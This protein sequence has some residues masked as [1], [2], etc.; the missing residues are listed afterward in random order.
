MDRNEI[1][2][3]A[4]HSAWYAYTVLALNEEGEPW[5][6][7]PEWQKNSIRDAVRFWDEELAKA[8]QSEPL[9]NKAA[10][11]AP[12]SHENWMKYKAEEG[13]K[14]GPVKDPEKKEHPCMVPYNDLPEDQKIKD[15]V[16][17]QAYLTLRTMIPC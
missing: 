6:T 4:C 15:L 7:A 5:E 8:D 17:L 14:Y 11:L 13:W 2:A 1:L 12:L 3:A 9:A 10:R 16:V